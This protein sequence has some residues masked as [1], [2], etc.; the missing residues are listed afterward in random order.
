MHKYSAVVQVVA[1]PKSVE[2]LA[3]SITI[4]VS[5]SGRSMVAYSSV[6]QIDDVPNYAYSAPLLS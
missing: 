5:T 2:L 4:E 6:Y 1:K 3:K